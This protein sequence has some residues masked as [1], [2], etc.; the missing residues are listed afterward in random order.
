MIF[1]QSCLVSRGE[2]L[3]VAVDSFSSGKTLFDGKERFYFVT[4]TQRERERE[5]K[6]EREREKERENT[7][8]FRREGFS[9]MREETQIRRYGHNCEEKINTNFLCWGRLQ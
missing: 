2:V 1:V 4:E 6:R 8:L 7:S 3:T 5:R 9:K